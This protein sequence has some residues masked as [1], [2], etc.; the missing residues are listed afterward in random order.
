MIA[1]PWYVRNAF[2]M[3]NP[4]YPFLFGG[5]YWD[6]FL[7]AW[8]ANSGTGIGWNALEIVSLPWNVVLGHRDV[9]FYD[10]RI[11]PLFLL[12]APLA[13]WT[14]IS[15][16]T[17]D[18]DRGHS[19]QAIAL[20]AGL[21]F[22]AWAFGVINSAALWQARL[23]LPALIPF[24][25]PT[26]L[27]WDSLSMLDTTRLRVS[28]LA[29]TVIAIVI[30]LTM[31]DNAMFVLQRNPVAVALGVQRREAY[32]AR[33]N[34]SYAALMQMMNELPEAAYAYHIFEPRSYGL[35]RRTQ[36]DAINYNFARDVHLYRMPSEII[37]QWKQNGYT[38]VILYERGLTLAVNDPSG[39]FS[40]TMQDALQQ[41][42]AQLEFIDRTPDEVYTMY[43]IP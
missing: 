18:T 10:G 42:L 33:V 17:R 25:V 11:G 40:A 9:T 28:F 43:R 1:S 8:Y 5:R 36:P 26:A 16:S 37:R 14:L 19:L 22:T 23:L 2:L 31:F 12:L 7:S 6:R 35:P 34:P 32:I 20:F 30:I 24:A 29:R 21:S 39:K 27:G 3:G 4:F 38:H 13:V 15:H 41:T